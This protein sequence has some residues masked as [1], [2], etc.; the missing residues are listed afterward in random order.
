MNKILFLITLFFL[1][2]S[3]FFGQ[4]EK[5]ITGVVQN[6]EGAALQNAVVTIVETR[7]Q[8]KTDEKGTFILRGVKNTHFSIGIEAEGCTILVEKK[9]ISNDTN[10]VFTLK[11][12][13]INLAT[14]TVFSNN[15]SIKTQE[16]SVTL[17][18]VNQDFIL[19]NQGATLMQSLEQLP[20]VTSINMGIGV[21]KPVIR[22]M[23]FNR[24]IVSENGIK[25]EGQQWGADHG[26]EIDPYNVENVEIIRGPAALMYGSDAMGG[27][28]DMRPKRLPTEGVHEGELTTIFRSVNN[29]FG[30]S[31]MAKGNHKGV[32]YR[33][34]GTYQ[35]Y[36][37]YKVPSDDFTYNGFVLP[38][39]EQRLKN[40]AGR[41]QHFSGTIGV[42]KAW[43]FTHLTVSNYAQKIGIFSGAIGIPRAYQLFHDGSYSDISTPRQEINHLKATLN[44]QQ[45]I[46]KNR[47]EIDAAFQQNDRLERSA[48]HTHTGVNTENHS[49][50]ALQLILKTYTLNGRWHTR[51]SE[52]I[53]TTLGIQSQIQDNQVNGFEFLIPNFSSR[54][55]GVFGLLNYHFKEKI[56]LNF[57][58][59][60]EGG[61]V[62]ANATTIPFYEGQRRVG[63]VERSPK[64]D[65][66]FG[67]WAG[68]LGASWLI[69]THWNLKLNVGKTFKLP[70]APELT[71]N[72]VHHG[73][74]RFEKGD[75]QLNPETG[76]QFDA[77]ITFNRK[78]IRLT[79][80]AFYNRFSNYIFL[81]PS[82]EFPTIALNDTLFPIPEA[83]Q[84]YRFKQ[85]SA[86]ILGSELEFF[87][88][89]TPHFSLNSNV[90][91]VIGENL[92]TQLPLPFI[93]PVSTFTALRYEW[94]RLSK[95]QKNTFIQ[96]EMAHYAPQNRVERNEKSTE[97]S[98]LF[99]LKTGTTWVIG[100]R[101]ITTFFSLQN[102]LNSRYFNH[103]SRYRLLNLPEPARNI[104]VTL[105]MTI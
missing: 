76:Y 32:V 103:L 88:Q 40:T 51:F 57:G 2:I 92:R 27:V 19:A 3:L 64:V 91:I 100:K 69:N 30:G 33:V 31:A 10:L 8:T 97:G 35:H 89:I 4:K 73:S 22:G 102:A 16:S 63:N 71:A 96:A 15:L 66:Q 54:T 50:L 68:G 80:T 18:H 1:N 28:V 72:G 55:V 12:L 11:S 61:T 104:A 59:R 58:L 7:F 43:G 62:K 41:E 45:V 86:Q 17:T 85:S 49:D 29:T 9:V 24:V 37:D 14:V 79:A 78:K 6:E 13:A 21:S 99:H 20:G 53:N 46:G 81:S 44:H 90:D 105:K 75:P 39:Y 83:G 70:T 65:E 101:Q 74:F 47:L 38:L 25:Q 56:H 95:H 93:P 42:Q 36:Q 67:N 48:P 94:Q 87:Y 5:I 23:S 34:R 77:A 98:T 26:L 84:V 52:K 82:S 60:T